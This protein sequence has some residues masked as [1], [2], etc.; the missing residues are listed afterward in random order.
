[1]YQG[2]I[3][4]GFGGQGV[5]SG[6]ILMAYSGMM[7]NKHVT[8]FP[9]YGAEMR[10]GTANCSV[11]ISTE[12][13]ASPV[14]SFPDS[15]LVMNEPSLAKFEPKLRKGGLMFL[16]STLVESRSKRS[17]I[18]TFEIPANDIAAELGNVKCAN[19]V[20]IGAYIKKTGAISIEMVKKSL[21]KVYV[22]ANEKILEMNRKAIDR[23]AALIK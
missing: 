8:F 5:V 1:M 20:M 19:M 9:A 11:V 23:G 15:I 14:V 16:N 2:V 4:A 10:G 7:D 12:E 18:E 3:M 13:I 17:D 22:R 6:G 21:G